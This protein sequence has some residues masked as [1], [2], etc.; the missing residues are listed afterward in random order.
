MTIAPVPALLTNQGALTRHDQ[1][2][3]IVNG[4]G[5]TRDYL[6]ADQ[7]IQRCS[8]E[9]RA[10]L[11]ILGALAK[12]AH[13][14]QTTESKPAENFRKTLCQLSGIPDDAKAIDF[15]PQLADAKY[16]TGET[17]QQAVYLKPI[18]SGPNPEGLQV[19]LIAW[20]GLMAGHQSIIF[21]RSSPSDQKEFIFIAIPQNKN[22]N[23]QVLEESVTKLINLTAGDKL[24]PEVQN[25]WMWGEEGRIVKSVEQAMKGNLI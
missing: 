12:K 16:S 24:P 9:N 18:V 8:M 2:M 17:Y 5:N 6:P 21:A 25:L 13:A 23:S 11:D 7:V 15:I 3:A 10:A 4:G 14:G 22:L 20:G 19:P 1:R